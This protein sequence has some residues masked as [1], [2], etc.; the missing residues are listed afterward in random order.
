[1]QPDPE[2]RYRSAD[3]LARDIQAYLEGRPLEGRRKAIL[4]TTGKFVRRNRLALLSVASVMLVFAVTAAAFAWR[5]TTAR[6]AAVAEAARVTRV[7]NFTQELFD[8]GDATAG[9]DVN[10]KVTDLLDRGK[11]EALNLSGDARLRARLLTTLGTSYG[12]LGQIQIADQLLQEATR[13]PTP[14]PGGAED[15]LESLAALAELRRQE[16]RLPEAEKILR[17]AIAA[18]T[19]WHGS[20]SLLERLHT[21]LGS[22]L[23][24]RGQ[25]K[26]AE[27]ELQ[28]A[29]QLRLPGS[30]PSQQ[31]AED[32]TQ[33]AEVD[34]YL[35]RY[36]AAAALNQQ[37]LQINLL[38]RGENHPAT[39]ENLNNLAAIAQ[40]H[41]EYEKA[42]RLLREALAIT[43]GWYGPD[44]PATADAL[45]A[46]S[47]SLLAASKLKEANS[48]LERAL[49]IQIHTYGVEHASVALT[50]NQLGLLASARNDDGTAE[51][52]FRSALAIW[53]KLYG[54][55][56]QFVALAY[57]N[58]AAVY[59]HRKTYPA[60]EQMCRKALAVYATALPGENVNSAVAH[61]R[62]GRILLRE[63]KLN[64]AEKES[65]AGYR[66]FAANSSSSDAYL[67]AARKDLGQIETGLGHPERS[68]QY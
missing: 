7:L 33:L 61:L 24:L 39:A 2:L 43:Q 26:E 25:Y 45:T 8:G 50:Y 10:L 9:P 34:H 62:L 31:Y 54:L 36:D 63:G 64:D 6:N 56:H 66:Y 4:Y 13:E 38:L 44:H 57:S 11:Q 22:V 21:D 27:T 37:A 12:K 30:A 58:L 60:A 16:R 51:K 5:L 53:Q 20:N 67:V 18:A 65:L 40:Y 48:A 14:L 32:L 46:L 59:A 42:E 52:D 15:H 35:G 19:L 68:A 28:N 55:N 29:L 17:Q 41:A 3:A 47:S 49:S 1:M 23:A